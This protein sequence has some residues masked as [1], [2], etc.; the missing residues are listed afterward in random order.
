MRRFT[1]SGR[2]AMPAWGMRLLKFGLLGLALLLPALAVKLGDPLPPFALVDPKGQEVTPA[3]LRKPA[4]IV[5]WASWCPVCRFEEESLAAIARD[6]PV[7]IIAMQSGNEDELRRYLAMRGLALPMIADADGRLARQ[8][9]VTATPTHFVLDSHGNIRF[10]SV[11]YSP[12]WSLRARL[13]WAGKF[14]AQ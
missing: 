14:P 11:G 12:A 10:R 13:F 2:I 7:L 9:S 5:F 4:V 3:T 8:W 1:H 6:W